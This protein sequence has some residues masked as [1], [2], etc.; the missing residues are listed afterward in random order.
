MTTLA[1]LRRVLLAVLLFGVAG[2]MLELVLIE[3]YEDGWQIAPLILLVGALVVLLWHT[4]RPNPVNVG[5]LQVLMAMIVV[6]GAL[7][8][9]FH[10]QGGAEF[11]REIDASQST[12][13]VFKKVVRAKAPPMLAPGLMTQLG[14]VGF[15]Y[16]YC[17]SAV[18]RL[19]SAAP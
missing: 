7:G 11:Q 16:L 17:H 9:W 4:A 18:A 10:Y 5:A 3:H 1:T 15:V 2:T 6:S 13:A 19:E 14:L 12:W 8:I